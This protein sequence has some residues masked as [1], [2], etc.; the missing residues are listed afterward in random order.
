MS[1][2]KDII[3]R[4]QYEKPITALNMPYQYA[5]FTNRILMQQMPEKKGKQ[6]IN[7]Y[8]PVYVIL[9]IKSIK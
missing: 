8:I 9:R 7:L 3:Y 6:F 4:R 5:G 1:Q 2:T